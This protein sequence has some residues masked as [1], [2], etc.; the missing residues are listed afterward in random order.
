MPTVTLQILARQPNDN[1]KATDTI[2]ARRYKPWDVFALHPTNQ[3]A[4]LTDGS[5]RMNAVIGT[6]AYVYIHVT[7]VPDKDRLEN[8]V[9]S[10][11]VANGTPEINDAKENP[12]I[13][14]RRRLWY[15]DSSLLPQPVKDALA[16]DG[17][18]EV[19]MTWPQLRSVC[20]KKKVTDGADASKD[21]QDKMLEDGDLGNDT[22]H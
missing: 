7:D 14:R 17:D 10:E 21:T 16:P 12:F 5:Y 11:Y 19:T 3:I 20:A 9:V 2:R 13:M 8:L 1:I 22:I 4:T 15:I 18:R 6:L